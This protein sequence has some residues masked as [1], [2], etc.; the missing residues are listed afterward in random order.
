MRL[1]HLLEEKISDD[2]AAHLNPSFMRAS[3]G[4]EVDSLHVLYISSDGRNATH[5]H[6][7][8]ISKMLTDVC[9]LRSAATSSVRLPAKLSG[10]QGVT[11][12]GSRELCGFD[13]SA[14]P[15]E[16]LVAVQAIALLT[17]ALKR[18]AEEREGVETANDVDR[19]IRLL[20]AVGDA[21]NEFEMMSDGDVLDS[22]LRAGP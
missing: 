2:R 16:R 7:R 6:R 14:L 20:G 9:T 19:H 4:K 10:I 17:R 21:A 1:P 11:Q 12:A 22:T 18:R 15:I 5:F 8:H 3:S 13:A